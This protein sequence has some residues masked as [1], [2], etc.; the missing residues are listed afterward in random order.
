M[1]SAG[2]FLQCQAMRSQ[3]ASERYSKSQIQDSKFHNPKMWFLYATIGQWNQLWSMMVN[4]LK[5]VPEI[6]MNWHPFWTHRWWWNFD[7]FHG[8]YVKQSHDLPRIS[9]MARE[10]LNHGIPMVS[11]VF[12]LKFTMNSE[13]R[14]ASRTEGSKSPFPPDRPAWWNQLPRHA[15]YLDP[16]VVLYH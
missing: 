8:R 5:L 1:S 11:P 12:T 6:H 9:D 3:A 13:I 7:I 16:V 4:H 10:T 2:G 15:K 14:D